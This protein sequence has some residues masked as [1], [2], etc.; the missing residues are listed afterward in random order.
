MF[1]NEENL[2]EEGVCTLVLEACAT[3]REDIAG[4]AGRTI[5][6]I[7]LVPPL[8]PDVLSTLADVA[9]AEALLPVAILLPGI[10]YLLI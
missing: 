6:L 5:G 2:A 7:F 9:G 10:G 8:M 1:L 4:I 3:V